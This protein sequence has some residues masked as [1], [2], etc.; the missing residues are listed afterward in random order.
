MISPQ[1]RAVQVQKEVEYYEGRAFVA[2]DKGMVLGGSQSGGWRESGNID[3]AIGGEVLGTGKSRLEGAQIAHPVSTAMVAEQG[4]RNRNPEAR[5]RSM[6]S[7]CQFAL[8]IAPHLYDPTGYFHPRRES[9]IV[10]RQPKS[11]CRRG[12]HPLSLFL[13]HL[14]FRNSVLGKNDAPGVCDLGEFEGDGH[15]WL[16]AQPAL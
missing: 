6:G 15:V 1:R 4:L 11:L 5:P 7:L 16:C 2:V 3:L 9:P 8:N 13:F 10:R 14:P 12:Q